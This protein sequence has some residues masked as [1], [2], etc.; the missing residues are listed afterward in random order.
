MSLW[1]IERARAADAEAVSALAGKIFGD[2]FGPHNSPADMELYS[3]AALSPGAMASAIADPATEILLAS[4]EGQPIAYAQLHRGA[5][6]ASVSGPAPIEL[7]RFY[8]LAGWH[9]QGLAQ[10]LMRRV[11]ERSIEL[12]AATLW[13]G[14]WEHNAR[15]I[16]F[17]T[18]YGFA[19]VGEQ[20]FLLGT[21]LQRD[22]VLSVP[23]D[24]LAG[25]LDT[26]RTN[27]VA[28]R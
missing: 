24:G 1:T 7:A 4:S 12:G 5:A 19:E 20:P 28:E 2:T 14:V 16:R 13:L 21:D 15:A 25:S 11:V 23:L 9:G 27:P 6:P 18:K 3:A 10:A 17:Y 8:V 22:L 26:P